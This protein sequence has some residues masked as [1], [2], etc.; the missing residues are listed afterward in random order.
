MQAASIIV[1]QSGWVGTRSYSL[2]IDIVPDKTM[3]PLAKHVMQAVGMIY[4]LIQQIAVEQLQGEIVS[5]S[6]KTIVYKERYSLCPQELQ[7]LVNK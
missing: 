5:D 1:P 3:K 2:P 7:N 4:F 6:G